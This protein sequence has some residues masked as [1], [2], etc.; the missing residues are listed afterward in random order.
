MKRDLPANVVNVTAA[1]KPRP[2][3][4]RRTFACSSPFVSTKSPQHEKR[5]QHLWPF[6]NLAATKDEVRER[7]EQRNNE[8]AITI[9]RSCVVS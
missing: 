9:K 7:D 4:S 5:N 6:S 2:S 3:V 1:K 8:A